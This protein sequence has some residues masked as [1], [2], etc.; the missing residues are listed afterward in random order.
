ML[1]RPLDEGHPAHLAKFGFVDFTV[2]GSTRS[3]GVYSLGF[4]CSGL[5]GLVCRPMRLLCYRVLRPSGMVT[6][7]EI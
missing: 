2:W 1:A 7:M 4:K 5:D 6:R 3:L